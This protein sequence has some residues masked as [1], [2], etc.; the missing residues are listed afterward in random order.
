MSTIS[1]WLLGIS[2]I[3]FSLMRVLDAVTGQFGT[4]KG[5]RGHANF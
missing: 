4:P 2:L 3:I 5:G 1:K